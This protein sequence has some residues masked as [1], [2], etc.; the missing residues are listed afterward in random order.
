MS[1]KSVLAGLVAC[2][3]PVAAHAAPL[4]WTLTDAVFADGGLA[5]GSFVWDADTQTLGDYAFSTSGGDTDVFSPA[6]YTNANAGEPAIYSRNTF[7]GVDIRLYI[8]SIQSAPN[9]FRNLYIS[10]TKDLTNA[11]GKVSLDLTSAYAA[12]EC[13]YCNPY[14]PF[15][16]GYLVADG[17]A[18]AV[19]EPATWAVMLVGFGALGGA[20]RRRRAASP[21]SA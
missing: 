9:D 10:V 5:T 1:S 4:T 21:A 20:L 2:L 3:L 7:N 15:A 6:A 16:S 14:R 12:G 13:F 11:G 19:P 17:G 18:G 8:F